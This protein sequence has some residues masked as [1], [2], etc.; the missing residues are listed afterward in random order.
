MSAAETVDAYL[1]TLPGTTR[2]LAPGEWGVT[3]EPDFAAGWPLDIGIRVA[4]GLLRAQAFACAHDEMLD[5]W[6]L[7][8][9]N[10]QT[11]FV[12]FAC[13]RNGD[14]W[15][16]ADL[17]AATTDERS[18]DRLLGLVVEGATVAR[19]YAVEACAARPSRS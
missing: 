13:A 18:V 1:A 3:V 5:P 9:W 16:H 11:R 4:D 15:V 19:R 6:L 7:L 10:R 2:R 17:P 8:N 14:V 12:R